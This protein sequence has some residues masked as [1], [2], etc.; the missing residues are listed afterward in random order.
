MTKTLKPQR[1]PTRRPTPILPELLL[2]MLEKFS[3]D[4]PEFAPAAARS[5]LHLD[6]MRLVSSDSRFYS[7]TKSSFKILYV[8]RILISYHI[9]ILILYFRGYISVR[10]CCSRIVCTWFW[11]RSLSSSLKIS[12]TNKNYFIWVSFIWDCIKITICSAKVFHLHFYHLGQT[13]LKIW[14]GRNNHAGHNANCRIT[15]T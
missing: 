11:V 13:T 15:R 4:P 14:N 12:S 6:W 7:W 1:R 10:F 2:K 8:I 9:R 3:L 5:L